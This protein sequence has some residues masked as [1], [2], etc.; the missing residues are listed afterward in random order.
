MTVGDPYANL[1]SMLKLPAAM[2]KTFRFDRPADTHWRTVDCKTAAE[3]G[4]CDHYSQ[5][6]VLEVP[7]GKL[8]D[9]EWAFRQAGY[10]FVPI[11]ARQEGH[12]AWFFKP[13]QPCLASRRA[14]HRIPLDREP[15]LAVVGGD[16]RGNPRGEGHTHTSVDSWVD[17]LHTH[18]DKLDQEFQKG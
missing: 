7:A 2:R 10:T 6:F 9:S 17:D 3:H 14:P 1:N 8:A 4:E 12:V 11:D 18:M 15:L 16:H 5:G 13:E